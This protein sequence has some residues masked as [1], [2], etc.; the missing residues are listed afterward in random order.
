YSPKNWYRG[1]KGEVTARIAFAQS[2]NTIAVKLLNE[3]GVNEFLEKI[4]MILDIDK[5]TLEKRFQPNLSLALG[6]GE[7]SPMELALIYATIANGGKKVSP[8]QILRITDFEGSE[9][10]STPLKDPNEVVQIL[11]P[12]ACAETI[13]LLEAVLSEQ[14]TMK[15][16]TVKVKILFR[17]EVKPERSNLPKKPEKNG[18]LAKE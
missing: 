1:Y 2:I 8:I 15:L 14:G 6:S 13:N 10:F 11:G 4:S 3:F 17:W 5:S 7:L 18:D 12:V 16:K 9:M